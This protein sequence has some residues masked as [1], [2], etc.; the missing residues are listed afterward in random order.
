[1][2]LSCSSNA[3]TNLEPESDREVLI[4]IICVNFK[5]DIHN[6]GDL[7]GQKMALKEPV[8]ARYRISDLKQA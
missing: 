6:P 1:M 4:R 7:N 8:K 2:G 5:D 3:R